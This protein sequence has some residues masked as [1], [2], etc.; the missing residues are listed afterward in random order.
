LLLYLNITGA[1]AVTN[2][3]LA[4]T[5]N[6]A[7]HLIQVLQ[8]PRSQL[9]QVYDTAGALYLEEFQDFLTPVNIKKIPFEERIHCNCYFSFSYETL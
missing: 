2:I 5:N 8:N 6:D 1:L 9:P 7:D 4:I 3:N